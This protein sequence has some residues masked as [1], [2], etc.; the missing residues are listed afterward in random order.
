VTIR[1][2]LFDWTGTLAYQ[3]QAS[4]VDPI[5]LLCSQLRHRG[6]EADPTRLAAAI[7]DLQREHGESI[8]FDELLLRACEC[9]GMA[10]GKDVIDLAASAF[11]RAVLSG[12]RLFDDA[13]AMLASLKYRGYAIAI[14]SNLVIPASMVQEQLRE[15]GVGGQVDAV[16]TSGDLGRAKPDPVIVLQALQAVGAIPAEALLVGDGL[17][18]D[19]AAASAAGVQPVLL[20]R[21]GSYPAAPYPRI[22]RL[23]GLNGLLGEGPVESRTPAV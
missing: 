6:W 4:T 12:Q 11:A 14:V 10:V 13:R 1:A 3:G 16:I 17:D 7:R 9:S 15:L 23:T 18:T 5:E 2:I 22:E 21:D 8:P 20:D 19:M